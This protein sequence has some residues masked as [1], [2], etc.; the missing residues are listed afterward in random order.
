[1]FRTT[2]S[3]VRERSVVTTMSQVN[4]F[5]E[6]H[7]MM[8]NNAF[9]RLPLHDLKHR[10]CLLREHGRLRDVGD[11][12]DQKSNKSQK[13]TIHFFVMRGW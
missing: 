3:D 9:L 12:R 13:N 6:I 10:L 5:G 1:M 2:G 11:R 7:F 8:R 4:T